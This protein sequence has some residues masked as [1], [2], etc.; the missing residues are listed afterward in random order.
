VRE[1]NGWAFFFFRVG[2]G[3]GDFGANVGIACIVVVSCL[4]RAGRQD[5]KTR[6]WDVGRQ[7]GRLI[8]RGLED[9][10]LETSCACYSSLS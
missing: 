8:D 10:D 5:R 2:R 9:G 3:W 4:F 6:R 1:G 7:G